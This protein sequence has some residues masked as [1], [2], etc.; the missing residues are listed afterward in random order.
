MTEEREMKVV[1]GGGLSFMTSDPFLTRAV[2]RCAELAEEVQRLRHEEVARYRT[3]RRDVKHI[4]GSIRRLESS[5][6]SR[7]RAP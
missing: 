3:L 6:A 2:R 1:S 7:E 5:P 4:K